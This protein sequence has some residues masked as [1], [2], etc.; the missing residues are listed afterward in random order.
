MCV[1]SILPHFIRVF[2]HDLH[3]PGDVYACY[4]VLYLLA[5]VAG[6]APFEFRSYPS[7]HL[8]NTLTGYTIAVIRITLY[9]AIFGY[10]MTH[11]QSLLSH[12]FVTE[13]SRF[14]DSLQKFNGMFGI[15]MVLIHS[16]VQSKYLICLMAEYEGVELHLSGVGIKFLQTKCAF[17]VNFTILAMFCA[18]IGFILYGSL[19]VF[20]RNGVFIS[21]IASISFYMP[22]LMVS[23]VAVLFS[24]V[25][26]KLTAY[27]DAINK[28]I[29]VCDNDEQIA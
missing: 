25:F 2:I 9:A 3:K 6:V 13:V 29:N 17:R 7:R 19:M 4:R 15:F 24:S 27:F 11:E 28:V 8:I 22:H 23:S 21:T 14:T 1:S 20:A 18:N 5:F 10:T 12:F 26:Y 16:L